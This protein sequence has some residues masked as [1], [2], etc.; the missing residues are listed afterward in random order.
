[1]SYHEYK[2]SQK[3]EM[4]DVPFYAIIMAA[5]RRADDNNLDKLKQAWPEIWDELFARYHAPGGKIGEEQ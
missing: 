2:A 5:M 1:V 4:E 3:L